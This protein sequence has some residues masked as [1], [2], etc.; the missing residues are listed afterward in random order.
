[1]SSLVDG[2]VTMVD[3]NPDRD[4]AQRRCRPGHAVRNLHCSKDIRSRFRSSRQKANSCNNLGLYDP[5]GRSRNRAAA[6]DGGGEPFAR[7]EA[8]G[9]PVA[10]HHA[11]SADREVPMRDPRFSTT[12]VLGFL[13]V[14]AAFAGPDKVPARLAQVRYVALAYDLGGSLLS[15]SD[16]LSKPALIA[17]EDRDALQAVRSQ[18]EKWGRYSITVRPAQA[19][20]LIAV[21]TGRR[22]SASATVRIG[23][24]QDGP[25]PAGSVTGGG[26]AVE[27]SS[28]GDLMTVYDTA[29]NGSV[30]LWRG[31]RRG[32]LS[33]SSPG[34]F[35]DFK[36]DVE[37]VSKHP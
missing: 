12:V 1:M 33:G 15:E 18:L 5:S 2:L 3:S 4:G 26:M 11:S 25:A 24:R 35:E 23:G 10:R 27:A 6:I 28:E 22:G 17:P 30:V 36:A 8:A 32:G 34:L 14:P 29:G 7:G 20:L 19:E 9:M 13:F 31:Q 16:A 21:R 37:R